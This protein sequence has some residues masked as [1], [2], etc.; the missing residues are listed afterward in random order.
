MAYFCASFWLDSAISMESKSALKRLVLCAP[1]VAARLI[2]ALL[3][4]SMWL[5]ACATSDST[6]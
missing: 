4:E 1:S 3:G 5:L 6:K 2:F